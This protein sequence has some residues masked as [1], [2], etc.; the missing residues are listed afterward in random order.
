[1]L[2]TWTRPIVNLEKRVSVQF[3]CQENCTS[4]MLQVGCSKQP[5][6]IYT[7]TATALTISHKREVS[8]P[9]RVRPLQEHPK[10]TPRNP[11]R[12]PKKL[13]DHS[14]GKSEKTALRVT[15]RMRTGLRRR[16]HLQ[17]AQ[18]PLQ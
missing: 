5:S 17:E 7:K 6:P 14:E 18:N 10:S 9:N 1:M 15:R 16:H 3:V 2:N 13:Q 11:P 8:S 12:P 4:Y